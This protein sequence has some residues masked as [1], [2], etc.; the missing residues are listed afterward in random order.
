M[1]SAFNWTPQRSAAA[2]ALA[3]GATQARAAE[4]AG[5]TDRTLRNWLSNSE[6][7]EEVDR[8]TLMTGIAT[9]GERLRIAKRVMRQFEDEETGKITTTRDLLEW[10]KFSRDETDGVRLDLASLAEALRGGAD[11]A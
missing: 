4:D 10:L 5:V 2:A 8:L 11:D 3:A 6:F 1:A 9:R 7:A